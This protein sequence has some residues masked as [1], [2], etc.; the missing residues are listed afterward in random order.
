M[1][2]GTFLIIRYQEFQIESLAS[3]DI[4]LTLPN[5]SGRFVCLRGVIHILNGGCGQRSLIHV[6]MRS[7]LNH[8]NFL[9]LGNLPQNRV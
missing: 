1:H 7:I 2:V 3:V 9:E 4:D 8:Q 5:Q 6:G